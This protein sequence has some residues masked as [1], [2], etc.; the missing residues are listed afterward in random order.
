M[1]QRKKAIS[2]MLAGTLALAL[3]VPAFAGDPVTL[4]FSW[5]GGD[6]RHEATLAVIEKFEEENPDIIIEPEYSSFDCYKE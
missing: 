3:A 2:V 4:R 5:W 1:V 6:E